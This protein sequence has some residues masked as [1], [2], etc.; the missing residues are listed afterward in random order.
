MPLFEFL[1]EECGHSFEL[2][3]LGQSDEFEMRCPKCKSPNIERLMS[4]SNFAIS[5]GN[6]GPRQ[7]VV[8]NHACSSGTCS[9]ITVPGL[10]RE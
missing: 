9:S 4:A 10:S 6:R 8:E 2:L 5:G 7:P 3:S 1:C